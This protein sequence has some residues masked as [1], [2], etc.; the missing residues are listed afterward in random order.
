MRDISPSMRVAKCLWFKFSNWNCS[1]RSVWKRRYL[2]GYSRRKNERY[3]SVLRPIGLP[4]YGSCPNAIDSYTSVR[5]D[6]PQFSHGVVSLSY[7]SPQRSHW[8]F[9]SPALPSVSPNMLAIR[10]TGF[11]MSV[12]SACA[13]RFR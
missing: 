3:R 13:D 1:T 12:T 6:P 9:A 8:Y 2:P 10:L 7:C 4:R 11:T 5:T